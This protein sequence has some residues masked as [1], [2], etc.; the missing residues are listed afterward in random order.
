MAR[1]GP[2]KR[3]QPSTNSE[4]SISPWPGQGF[5]ENERRESLSRPSSADPF[6]IRSLVFTDS[7]PETSMSLKS[8]QASLVS[9]SNASGVFFAA[10]TN[11][12]ESTD[13]ESSHDES[14]R[15]AV[16]QVRT[17]K[18]E[19]M[20]G[21]SNKCSN[22]VKVKFWLCDARRPRSFCSMWKIDMNISTW[23]Q[24]QTRRTALWFGITRG[25][26]HQ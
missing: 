21:W 13:G 17:W 23:K 4:A 10:Q 19:R 1:A 16:R 11:R 8:V 7:V 24:K 26:R 5:V 6:Q 12:V 22:S 15:S 2:F 20:C 9:T 18:N 3:M 25:T 14:V